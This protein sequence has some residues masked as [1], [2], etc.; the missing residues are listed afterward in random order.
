[1]IFLKKKH[2]NVGSNNLK[3]F[4]FKANWCGFFLYFGFE[5]LL[6]LLKLS[7]YIKY[8]VAKFDSWSNFNSLVKL[9]LDGPWGVQCTLYCTPVYCVHFTVHCT[10]YNKPGMTNFLK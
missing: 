8:L 10:V 5:G 2:L 7:L 1:M 3:E 4:E 6:K 9:S